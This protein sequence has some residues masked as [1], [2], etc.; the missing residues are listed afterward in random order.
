MFADSKKEKWRL[1]IYIRVFCEKKEK[2]HYFTGE[3]AVLHR[4]HQLYLRKSMILLYTKLRVDL[5]LQNIIVKIASQLRQLYM[6]GSQLALFIES[7]IC[8]KYGFS[9]WVY[10]LCTVENICSREEE[11]RHQVSM[12]KP[13]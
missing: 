4:W 10:V 8:C 5:G 13:I 1:I 12:K 9:C 2:K 7:H 11:V 6:T 3:E